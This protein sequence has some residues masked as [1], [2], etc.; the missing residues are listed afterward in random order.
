MGVTS[1][2]ELHKEVVEILRPKADPVGFK[3]LDEEPRLAKY[4]G[5]A[6]LCQALK[7]AGVIGRAVLLDSENSSTCLIGRYIAGLGELPESLEKRWI[8]YASYTHEIYE[9]LVKGAEKVEG[10]KAF[11]AAPLKR[12]DSYGFD[13]DGVFLAVNSAQAYLLVVSLFDSTGRRTASRFSGHCGLRSNSS[14]S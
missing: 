8:E 7:I 10:R 2:A 13:P 5:R 3:F 9:S 1:Y 12:F 11:L 6:A 4:R 14:C